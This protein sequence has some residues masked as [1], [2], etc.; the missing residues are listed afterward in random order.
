MNESG[1]G[2]VA[3]NPLKVQENPAKILSLPSKRRFSGH[4]ESHSWAHGIASLEC[5][6]HAAKRDDMS[7]GQ[8]GA[9]C[10][11]VLGKARSLLKCGTCLR[12]GAQP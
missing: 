9:I 2:L 4:D 11:D 5:L 10:L 12:N 1:L 7:S 6:L 3:S 8:T